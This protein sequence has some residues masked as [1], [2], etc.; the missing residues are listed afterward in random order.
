MSELF[1]DLFIFEMANNHQGNVEHGLEII[2]AMGQIAQKYS[3]RA[4]VKLQYRDLET[5]I[6]PDFKSRDDVKHIPRFFSTRLTGIEFLT[7]VNAVR[8]QHMIPIATPFDEPSI[9][10]CLEHDIQ[11]IKVGSCSA[12][13]WPLLERIAMT[14][15]PVIVSTGGIPISDIDNIVSFFKHRGI[16]FALMHCV[17]I[18]PTPA[19]M[20]QMN[21]ISKLSRRYP[22]T[23]IGYSGHEA[24]DNLDAV[25]IAV[26]KGAQILERHVGIATN[27]IKL[28]TYSMT[29]ELTDAWVS[30]ALTAREICGSSDNKQVSQA[31]VKSLLSLKRGAYAANDIRKGNAI[32]REEIFFAMP[33]AEGQTGAEGFGRYRA[34][35]IAS[36]NY[37]RNEAICEQQQLDVVTMIRGVI[38]DA[39]GM[40]C[41]AQIELGDDPEI[42]LSH[43][44]GIEH[45]RQIGALIV[46]LVNREYCKKIIVLLPSQQHPNHYH[47]IKEETFQLL[48]GDMEIILDGEMINMKPGDRKLVKRNTWHSFRSIKGAIIEEISTTHTKGDS[49]YEDER[50]NMLD[51]MQRK[52]TVESW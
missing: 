1:K 23:P 51:I 48:S 34:T 22:N 24:S 26:S 29:P 9:E 50:I 25:K 2:N 15:K 6:H 21:F 8:A 20:L 16:C 18:Y 42:E 3:I 17:G 27:T 7:L 32:R 52:T 40:L 5:F 45:I 30:S 10:Q 41:E 35:F 11:I 28:N 43:H 12:T 4:G 44:H 19:H 31:E 37:K 39:K 33:C 38:H 13:D 14:R 36:K 46:N 47:R 49:Y